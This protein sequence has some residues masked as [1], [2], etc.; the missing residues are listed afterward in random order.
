MPIKIRDTIIE[1]LA[2]LN[3]YGFTLN[4]QQSSSKI[5]IFSRTRGEIIE[6]VTFDLS[7]H[8]PNSIRA[9]INTSK[10]LKAV[11]VSEMIKEKGETGWWTFSDSDSLRLIVNELLEAIIQYGIPWFDRVAKP[12]PQIPEGFS[13]DLFLNREELADKFKERY[14]IILTDDT[15]LW[16]IEEIMEGLYRDNPTKIVDWDLVLEA[17]A[18]YGEFI[19]VTLG[20]SWK[21]HEEVGIAAIVNIAGIENSV[22]S[23]I[24]SLIRL[25]WNP[26]EKLTSRYRV[27]KELGNA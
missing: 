7:N 4:K 23:P 6:Y 26:F 25:W 16:K 3:S 18:F 2:K 1:A 11:Y 15:A 21:W 10:Q 27:L 12:I 5:W 8:F 20:A 13:K 24:I 22:V 14:N 19:R 17:S 9:S